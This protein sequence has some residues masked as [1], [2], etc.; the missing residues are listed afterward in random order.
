MG[1]AS[2]YTIKVL[3][4]LGGA[5]APMDRLAA[6][7]VATSASGMATFVA[8]IGAGVAVL[9]WVYVTN[10]NAHAVNPAMTITPGWAVG[11]FFI[12]VASL[13]KPFDGLRQTWQTAADPGS[14][15]S[16]PVP[17]LLRIWWGC[18][19][20]SSILSNIDFRLTMKAETVEQVITAAWVTVAAVPVDIATTIALA[21][22][23]RRLSQMQ[24][25]T[26]GGTTQARPETAGNAVFE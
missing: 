1:A 23:M 19:I 20:T 14:P 3:G 13:F 5:L 24:R 8:L 2:L 17:A 10:R 25:D 11:W 7:D 26:A 16:V 6:A 21:T 18:W 12:P 22:I 9:R 15:D 4:G